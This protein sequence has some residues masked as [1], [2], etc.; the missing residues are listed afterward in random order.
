MGKLIDLTGRV[1][2]RL[3]VTAML[4]KRSNHGQVK[5]AVTCSCGEIRQVCGRDLRSGHTKSCGCYGLETRT[6]A[7]TKHG[8]AT[9]ANRRPEYRSWKHAKERCHN[10]RTKAWARYG[11]RGI[12]MCEEW[13]NSFEAFIAHVGPKPSPKHSIDRINNDGNYEPGNVRWATPKEQ[14]AN[15]RRYKARPWLRKRPAHADG[16]WVK[17]GEVPRLPQWAIEAGVQVGPY[18][19]RKQAVRQT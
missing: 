4:P 7:L 12:A 8:W 13:R 9:A 1:F 19:P 17:H 11:G 10:P 18:L 3:T 6:K 15:Q 2:G 5:W 14:V 16:T